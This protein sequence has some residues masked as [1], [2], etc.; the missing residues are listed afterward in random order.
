MIGISHIDMMP[1]FY[2]F[3]MFLGIWSMYRKL[4]RLQIAQF[5][6][7]VFTFWLVFA[8]HGGTMAGGFSAMICALLCGTFL[9]RTKK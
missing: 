3:V 5:I 9:G 6:I 7:E 4:V 1:L 2:G 8:L